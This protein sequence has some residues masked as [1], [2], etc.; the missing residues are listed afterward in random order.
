MSD[1]RKNLPS[2][3]GLESYQLCLG[4][5]PLEKSIPRE[6][7]DS[8]EVSRS[9]DRI[10]AYMAGEIEHL[11]ND[12]EDRI[13][14]KFKREEKE[15]VAEFIGTPTITLREERFWFK[16]RLSAKLDAAF[17]GEDAI[18][19][20][21]YKSG[22][23]GATPAHSN[24]QL[25]A[26]LLCLESKYRA[27]GRPVYV[28]VLLRFGKP[29]VA[30]YEAD[31]IAAA[32]VEMERVLDEI[33]KP[34]QPLTP[35]ERACMY[36]RAKTICPALQAQARELVVL[37]EQRELAVSNIVR[38]LDLK[39]QVVKL[40][41]QAELTAKTM[42]ANDPSSVPGWEL[43]EGAE[44]EKITDIQ[45]VYTR[46]SEIGVP[47]EKF[48]A[49]CTIAKSSLKP[50]IR[51]V[52]KKKGKELDMLMDSVIAGCVETTKAAPSLKRTTT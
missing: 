34:D 47:M 31:D 3:S 44:R 2:A 25:R 5:W 37:S 19:L 18:L 9:G 10:H 1:E 30:K 26:Q 46:V 6:T 43:K 8:T 33:E 41:E 38:I 28:A 39:S 35:S 17:I 4:K 14:E 42:L 15:L 52:T 50:L 11:E 51:D 45:K 32:A 40:I 48:T 49:A 23:L 20:I 22:F 12:D 21:D 36:C 7:D 24:P 16:D 29:S 13:G 27:M